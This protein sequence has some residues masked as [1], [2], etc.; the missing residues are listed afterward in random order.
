MT[1]TYF[2]KAHSPTTQ[3]SSKGLLRLPPA[4]PSKRYQPTV[5][6][7]DGFFVVQALLVLRLHTL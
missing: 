5:Q 7:C 4:Q 1:R 2:V 6:V 3:I